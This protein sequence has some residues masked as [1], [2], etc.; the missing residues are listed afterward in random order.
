MQKKGGA[1]PADIENAAPYGAAFFHAAQGELMP[2]AGC[3]V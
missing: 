3:G 2:P 1:L